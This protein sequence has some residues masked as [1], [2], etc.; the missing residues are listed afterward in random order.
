MELRQQLL[1]Q[2]RLELKPL[3]IQAV[4][5]LPLSQLEIRKELLQEY[6][7]NPAL[8]LQSLEDLPSFESFIQPD[9]ENPEG[10]DDAWLQSLLMDRADEV[11]THTDISAG[12]N[13]H[14]EDWLWERWIT[15]PV[16]L[17]D[18]LRW[19]I[20]M[21]PMDEETRQTCYF[22]IEFLNPAGYLDESNDE[23]AR[24]AGVSAEAI[25][26]AR[27]HLMELD[28]PGVGARNLRECLLMQLKVAGQEESEAWKLLQTG[29]EA[30]V[31]G[32]LETV[33]HVMG[34][35]D[36]TLEQA[37]DKVRHLEPRPARSFVP[38]QLFYIYPDVIV[39]QENDRYIVEVCRDLVP[40]FGLSRR[41]IRML[42]SGKLSA[43]EKKYLREKI[44][45]ARRLLKTLVY[46][47]STLK[48]VAKFLV[49]H[50]VQFLI[51]GLPGLRPLSLKE[52]AEALELH[53]ST[54]SR[55]VQ[56][57]YI[58]TPRG[59]F[60]M[61]FFFQRRL[62]SQAAREGISTTVVR[63][64][65]KD[66]IAREDSKRPLTDEALARLLQLEGIRI[67][68]RAVSKYRKEMKIPN[69]RKRT[70]RVEAVETE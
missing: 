45:S 60:E 57:K 8:E 50:Q 35:D 70:R 32:N 28:P 10:D 44:L 62:P 54:I 25:E 56:H 29:W 26:V 23:L 9:S 14:G 69:V 33:K 1:P 59:T 53:E 36:K 51:E 47:E 11:T 22:L 13:V 40:N 65:L 12:E 48:R 55:T 34:W 43:E 67:S 42:R 18:H 24:L 6:L 66:L 37:L 52:V 31:S 2:Q 61:R 46:C 41:Y 27:K 63:L 30:L 38:H 64:K 17:V 19:Q 58:Q 5:L 21:L 7:Q 68:R 16:T 49:N 20:A 15:T 4:R 3:L 39:K